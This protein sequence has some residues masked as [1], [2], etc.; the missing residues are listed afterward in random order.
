MFS[1]I[2]PL[3][4]LPDPTPDPPGPCPF[5]RINPG[6]EVL[7]LISNWDTVHLFNASTAKIHSVVVFPEMK[8]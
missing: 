8:P 4:A 6:A 3:P 2:N 1:L 7:N 5:A